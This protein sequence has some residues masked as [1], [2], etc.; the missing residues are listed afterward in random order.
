LG[1]KN[2]KKGGEKKRWDGRKIEN[3]TPK[4]S[5]PIPQH[6]EL[7]RTKQKR[8]AKARHNNGET[9]RKTIKKT[10]G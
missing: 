8:V 9:K 5:L 4:N 2:S 1:R 7:E 6:C 3:V 10:G